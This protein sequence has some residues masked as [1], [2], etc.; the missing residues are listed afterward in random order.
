MD[1]EWQRW[2]IGGVISGTAAI[3]GVLWKIVSYASN[4]DRRLHERIDEMVK[5]IQDTVDALRK[6]A[7]DDR[8]EFASGIM[9]MMADDRSE[10]DVFREKIFD[11]L[12]EVA[13]QL[14]EIRGALG[15]RPLKTS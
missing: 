11:R 6:E 4:G 3:G 10:R 2:V 7:K 13:E 5:D 8:H 14:G 15:S 9:R 1:D 12:G